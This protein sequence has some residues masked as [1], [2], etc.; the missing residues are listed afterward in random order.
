VGN[1]FY[2]IIEVD[3]NGK[4]SKSQ[5]VLVINSVKPL[6]LQ[7]FP[8]PVTN[9]FI[10]IRLNQPSMVRIFGSSGDL[11]LSKQLGMGLQQVDLQNFKPGIYRLNV[12]NETISIIK[13]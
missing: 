2:R 10:N 11:L 4:T 7:A 5:I 3:F 1:N 8:N 9:G 12:F 13:L 6:P